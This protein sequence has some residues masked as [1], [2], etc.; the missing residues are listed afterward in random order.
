MK[1]NDTK[2]CGPK[3]PTI[4]DVFFNGVFRYCTKIEFKRLKTGI[5]NVPKTI[6][7]KW[8]SEHNYI[9]LYITICFNSIK[10][11][12]TRSSKISQITRSLSLSLTVTRNIH[13]GRNSQIKTN[14]WQKFRFES[15]HFNYWTRIAGFPNRYYCFNMPM[16]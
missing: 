10:H 2:S 3:L 16:R 4:N 15:T 6:S 11:D 7:N 5:H 14:G 12:S 13:L 1:W 8:N 9:R